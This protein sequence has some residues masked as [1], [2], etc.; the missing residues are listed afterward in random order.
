[1]LSNAYFMFPE[2]SL[3]RFECGVALFAL[4]HQRFNDIA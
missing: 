1:M 3:E 2:Q 4:L